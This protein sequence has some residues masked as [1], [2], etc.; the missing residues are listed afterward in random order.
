VDEGNV[1]VHR[2]VTVRVTTA[3]GRSWIDCSIPA[4]TSAPAVLGYRSAL[5]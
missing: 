1:S 3:T 5:N 4:S 2:D